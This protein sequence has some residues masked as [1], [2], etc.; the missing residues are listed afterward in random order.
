MTNTEIHRLDRLK[1][2]YEELLFS[3]ELDGYHWKDGKLLRPEEDVLDVAEESG[4]LATLYRDLQLADESTA[5]HHL[6]LSEDHYLAG[7]WDDCISNSLKF[8]ECTLSA[9]AAGHSCKVKGSLLPQRTL[10]QPRDVRDY[11]ERET[12]IEP[13]EKEALAKVYGLLSHT[14][15]HPYMADKDQARLLRHMA[16]TLTQFALLRYQGS[17]AGAN[18]GSSSAPPHSMG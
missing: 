5:L 18:T 14:G 17:L 10:E 4:F 11:L 3:L 12:L 6:Q 8:F 16:L 13:K 2:R 15:G 1:K 7:R 9:I